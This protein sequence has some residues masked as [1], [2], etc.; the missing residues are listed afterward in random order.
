MSTNSR[1]TALSDQV[2]EHALNE[3]KA[4]VQEFVIRHNLCPFARKPFEAD[5]VRFVCT[6]APDDA[7]LLHAL[8]QEFELLLNDSAIETTL[9]IV[10]NALETF[11]DYWDF[12]ALAEALIES[13]GLEGV[14]QIATFHPEY[15]FDGTEPDAPENRTNRSPYPTLHLLRESSLE[16]AIANHPD[17]TGIPKN[18]IKHM[19]AL[20]D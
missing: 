19:R 2:K 5:Q 11:P 14:F 7:A 15:Q 20:A 4:W 17:V 13:L 9:I 18:N 16:H 10:P 1:N 3:T 6:D 12:I 8:A